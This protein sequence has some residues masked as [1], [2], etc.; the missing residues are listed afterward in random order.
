M[1]GSSDKD[2]KTAIQKVLWQEIIN[3][4]D[5]LRENTKLCGLSKN[6]NTKYK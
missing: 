1:L 4:L 2:L 6:E 3:Y 5:S